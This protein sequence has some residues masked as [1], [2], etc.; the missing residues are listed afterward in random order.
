MTIPALLSHVGIDVARFVK[1]DGGVVFDGTGAGGQPAPMPLVPHRFHGGEDPSPERS[2]LR[3]AWW[4]VE[5][6]ARAA[7]A[8]AVRLHFPSF[9][10]MAEDDDYAFYGCID[11]GRGK[12]RVLVLP[13]PDR[14]LPTIV[15]MH[16]DLGRRIGRRIQRPPHLYL[17]GA[18]C[19]ASKSDWDPRLHTTAT[20][21]G[22][23]AHWFAA[24][25]EWRF[26]G[27]WPV[28]GYGAAA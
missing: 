11:T 10:E 24:Y 16:T 15:P 18:L 27:R 7:D 20:A 4:N 26:T 23:G 8:E 5:P 19:V 21:I 14:S 12:F 9:V 25:T 6:N 1:P 2:N 17:S 22:W 28:D 3:E 13:H